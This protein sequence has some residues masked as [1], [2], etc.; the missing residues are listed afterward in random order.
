MPNRI[1]REGILTSPKLSR[2][3]WAAEVFYRRL[4]SV[5]DDFGRYY[6]D[7]GMLRAACY[8]RQLSQVSDADADG[9]LAECAAAGLVRVYRMPDGERYLEV[10]NFGQQVRAKKSKFPDPPAGCVADAQQML[11]KCLADDKSTQ[12]NEHLDVFVSVSVSEDGSARAHDEQ[13]RADGADP[14]TLAGKACLAL[15]AAGV[16]GVNPSHPQL[17]EL[18]ATG[19]TPKQ[20]G[21]L[22]GE[23]AEARGSPPK[24]A[25]VLATMSGRLRDAV[26]K[27]NA[28]APVNGTALPYPAEFVGWERDDRKM[29]GLC[30]SLGLG[31]GPPG[32]TSEQLRE[33]LRGKLDRRTRAAA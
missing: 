28:P 22:A 30:R 15:K 27:A 2:L 31:D 12:T 20:L 21:D 18:L 13:M 8:P 23:L 17:A 11:S 29:L 5:V 9:W 3:G 19:V 26:A 32:Y 4:M 33:Y 25:Y 24:F 14:P 6:A 1:L 16:Q 7:P 10:L